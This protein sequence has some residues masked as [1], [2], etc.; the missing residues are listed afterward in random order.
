MGSDQATVLWDSQIVTDRHIHCNKP[1]IVMKEKETVR[2]M[3]IDVAIPSDYNIL[4]MVTEKMSKY[5]GLQI[6]FER[7]WSKKVEVTP[8]ITGTTGIVERNLKKIPKENTMRPQCL[9]HKEIS[10]TWN[11]THFAKKVLSIKPE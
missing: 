7:M 4:T 8:V 11:S 10:N 2:C 6:E 9:Q 1:N 5:R 3:V